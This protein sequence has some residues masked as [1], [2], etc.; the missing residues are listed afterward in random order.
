[1]SS[2]SGGVYR[3]E[4]TGDLEKM[5]GILTPVTALTAGMNGTLWA[6]GINGLY[7]YQGDSWK[8]ILM[9]N[10]FPA[11][12]KLLAVAQTKIN[13]IW[14]GTS[15]G[16]MSYGLKDDILDYPQSYSFERP[17]TAL[18]YDVLRELFWVGTEIGIF[19]LYRWG[20]G[21]EEDK[22]LH[23]TV[24]NSGLASNNILSLALDNSKANQVS[25]WIGTSCGL[26]QFIYQV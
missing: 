22:K 13:Q 3:F 20:K 26:S 9:E 21:W 11:G 16:L 18:A 5:S 8:L 24:H 6:V 12:T 17:T 25:L 7:R 19:G 1:M 10:R 4:Q 2:W 14:L 23:M 15:N